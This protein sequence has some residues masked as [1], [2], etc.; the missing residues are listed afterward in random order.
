MDTFD[1]NLLDIAPLIILG[2]IQIAPD[3]KLRMNTGLLGGDY[4]R[5]LLDS[6]NNKRIYCILRMNKETFT[7]LCLWLR[8]NGGLIDSWYVLIK[9]QVAIFLWVINFNASTAIV[10]ERF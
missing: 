1:I 4:L 3:A 7:L 6:S 5:E 10:A 9:E 8:T 2:A